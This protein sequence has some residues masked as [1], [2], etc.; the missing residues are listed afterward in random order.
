MT[1]ERGAGGCTWGWVGHRRYR[2]FRT[3][4]T[5]ALYEQLIV[6]GAWR[7]LVDGIATHLIADL[8]RQYPADVRRQLLTWSGSDNVWLR[9]TSIICQVGFK[10][11]TDRELLYACIEP[12]L[13]EREFFL[14]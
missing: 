6:S 11:A 14:R 3:M 5:L 12:C 9:R 8:L 7:D 2:G 4:Q 1:D 13:R 10:Q